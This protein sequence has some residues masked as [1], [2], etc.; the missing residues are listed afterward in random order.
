MKT[1]DQ[2]AAPPL[3][4]P[5]SRVTDPV[6]T[7]RA[8]P[9][10]ALRPS[11]WIMPWALDCRFSEVSRQAMPWTFSRVASGMAAKPKRA[12]RPMRST[13]GASRSD[14]LKSKYP[15]MREPSGP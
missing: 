3:V 2:V 11:R 8:T 12:V 14:P 6:E 7:V 15:E 13:K 10:G 4:V 5:T 1:P 9:S